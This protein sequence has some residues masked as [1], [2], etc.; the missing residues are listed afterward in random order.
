MIKVNYS[1]I[2]IFCNFYSPSIP[3]LVAGISISVS[4]FYTPSDIFAQIN[5]SHTG[6]IFVI[7]Q[8]IFVINNYN[9]F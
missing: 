7:F 4:I 6:I 5:R 8:F 3:L 2:N 9:Q 1:C